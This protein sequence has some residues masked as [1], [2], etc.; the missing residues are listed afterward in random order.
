[1]ANNTGQINSQ[2]TRSLKAVKKM[3]REKLPGLKLL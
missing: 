1:L 3:S 2:D